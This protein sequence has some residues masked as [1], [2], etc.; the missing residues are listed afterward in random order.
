VDVA[1][2]LNRALSIRPE[3]SIAS[4]VVNRRHAESAFAQ[5]GVWPSL[6][7]VV[8]YDRFGISGSS[9]PTGSG[10]AIPTNLDGT[11]SKSFESLGRG[12]YD[13]VRAGVVPGAP[14]PQSLRARERRRGSPRRAAGRGGRGPRPEGDPGRGAG[15]RG[16]AR[17]RRGRIEAARSGREAAEVQLSAERDRYETG[18]STNFLVLTRQNDLSRARLDEISALTDYRMARTEMARATGSADRGSRNRRWRQ[19]TLRRKS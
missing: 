13:A 6:D 5:D 9:N 16:I 19:V 12:D 14:D 15:R 8:S 2:S 3:L 1:S 11:F 4:A 7:A 18:M 17:D 10:G